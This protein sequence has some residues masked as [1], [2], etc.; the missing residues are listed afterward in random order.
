MA[1]VSLEESPLPFTNRTLQIVAQQ[2]DPGPTLFCSSDA[3]PPS[4]PTWH[5]QSEHSGGNDFTQNVVN[6][7]Q[8][9]A[10]VW[11]RPLQYEDSGHYTCNADNGVGESVVKLYLLVKSKSIFTYCLGAF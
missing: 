5:W 3:S 9:L 4:T 6:G 10:M 7:E 2:G 11:N 8:G 1:V